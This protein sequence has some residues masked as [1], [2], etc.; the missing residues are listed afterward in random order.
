MK[1]ILIQLGLQKGNIVSKYRPN[2]TDKGRDILL[3]GMPQTLSRRTEGMSQENKRNICPIIYRPVHSQEGKIKE[4]KCS[5]GMYRLQKG[6]QY[7]SANLDNRMSECVQDIRESSKLNLER[8]KKLENGTNT[9]IGSSLLFMITM[10]PFKEATNL[11]SL[12]KK[13]TH[14]CI[15]MIFA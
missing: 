4:Q 12:K 15:L 14:L 13:L 3:A 5:Y 6:I 9:C 1:T 2:C 7:D 8:C 10:M 11:Q